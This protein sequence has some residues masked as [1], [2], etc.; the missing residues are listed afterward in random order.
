MSVREDLKAACLAVLDLHAVEHPGGHQSA[1][2]S[3][4]ILRSANGTRV[5]VL[6]EKG[7]RGPANLWVCEAFVEALIDSD[8]KQRHSPAAGLNQ[9]DP[10]T[11]KTH[12]GRHS[13]L[14]SMRQLGNADLVCFTL[15]HVSQLNRIVDVLKRA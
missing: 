4:Y 12:Y 10:E 1:Y 3:R 5:E 11:G 7:S 13:A 8:I 2:A 9:T 14:R 6:F 15:E